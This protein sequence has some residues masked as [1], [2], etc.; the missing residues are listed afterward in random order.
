MI[1]KRS[2]LN[3]GLLLAQYLPHAR[4]LISS[5]QIQQRML[6]KSTVEQDLAVKKESAIN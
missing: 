4:I 1:S 6:F 3:K 2:Y 5:Y